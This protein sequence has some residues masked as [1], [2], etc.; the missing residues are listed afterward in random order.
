MV[1][2]LSR[3]FNISP[4]MAMQLYTPLFPVFADNGHIFDL[5]EIGIMNII[6]HDASLLRPDF[7]MA[8][9]K[10]DPIA[11][12]RPHQDLIDRWFPSA[13]NSKSKA[14]EQEAAKPLQDE[15]RLSDADFAQALSIRRSESKKLNKMYSST[16]K[17]SLIGA[18]S[19]CLMLNVFGGH[20]EDLR[21]MAGTVQ[22]DLIGVRS[23]EAGHS[24]GYER[25]PNRRRRIAKVASQA[26][27]VSATG[28][29]WQPATA[30]R[31]FGMTIFEAL[32]TT[33]KIEMKAR[34]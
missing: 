18:G 20:V 26:S 33:F 22:D 6:E 27:A 12:S 24:Y 31:Y 15:A 23:T 21:E 14:S 13:S 8:D 7:Y 25:I 32:W 3:A 28:Q 5:D 17:Q 2:G 16:V 4:T 10:H 9:W 11:M 30:D 1:A 19:C 34:S 29:A